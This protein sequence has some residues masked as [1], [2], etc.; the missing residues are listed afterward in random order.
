LSQIAVKRKWR[1]EGGPLLLVS[2]RNRRSH[3]EIFFRIARMGEK[4]RRRREQQ[5]PNKVKIGRKSLFT[6]GCLE[7]V[8]QIR[9]Y[10]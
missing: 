9:N 2:R 1:E 8:A 4:R 3:L 7:R 10:N 6:T 5:L